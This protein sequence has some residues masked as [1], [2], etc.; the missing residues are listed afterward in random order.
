[1]YDDLVME[2][3]K[4]ARNYRVLDD[5]DRR[6]EGTNPMCGDHMLI[7]F[8]LDGERLSEL[9][10]Q[11]TCCGISMASASMMTEA[12]TGARV[13]DAIRSARELVAMLEE[14]VEPG[15]SEAV[16]RLAMI[17][18][19]KRFPARTRCAVLP[20]RTLADALEERGT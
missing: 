1:M 7:Y 16:E 10:F 14:G 15:P 9:A 11:C 4:N 20:W 18:T 13:E 17:D 6:V 5:A 8:K 2:H 3:I 19:V 12:M